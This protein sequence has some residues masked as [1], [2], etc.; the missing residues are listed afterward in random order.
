MAHFAEIANDGTVLNIIVLDNDDAPDPAPEVSEPAGQEFIRSLGIP[1]IWVQTS[2]NSRG[3]KRTHYLTNEVID[4]TH[5]RYNYATVGGTFDPT[6]GSDG[7]FIPPKPTEGE[8]TLDPATA[9]WVE[10]TA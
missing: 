5:F 8:W 9:T 7:A 3:G 4:D 10:V 6:F 2:Y 1:G